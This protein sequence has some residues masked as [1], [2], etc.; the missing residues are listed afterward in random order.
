VIALTAL[1][2]VL[3]AARALLPIWLKRH[4]NGV[5]ERADAYT[6]RV[7]DIDVALV[8]GAY[9]IEGLEIEKE[10]GKVKVPL[11]AAREIDLSI[12]WKALI[13]GALVGEADVRDATLN[14]V[15]GPTRAQSQTG[16]EEN[17]AERLEK[18][19]PFEFDRVAVTNGRIHFRAPQRDPPVDVALRD[20][21]IEARNLTNSREVSA[22]R[23]ARVTARARAEK[24]G[25]AALDLSID[26]F[27]ARPDFRLRLELASLD[28][29]NLADFLRAYAGVDAQRGTMDVVSEVVSEDGRFD[30]YIQPALRDVDV[31]RIDEEIG[32]QSLFATLWEALVG[33][34][35]EL[36]ENQPEDQLA[37]RI[38]L[39]G[40]FEEP[41]LGAW[42]AL[43]SLFQNG[44]VEAL[45]PRVEL[46]RE[47]AKA[48]S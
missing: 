47:R 27:A 22:Q 16:A 3:V 40:S 33:G 10:N 15:E 12:E 11:F 9:R 46:L 5:L 7:I 19:F 2:A 14:F 28:L 37:A 6:G 38:P 39:S 34:T 36:L 35:A 17:W 8:R 23:P 21:T 44:Y 32:E 43:V 4:V 25:R 29:R 30:G 31:L 24:S 18:L 26:P 45:R 48:R 41:D 13:H 42:G 20:V 1:V